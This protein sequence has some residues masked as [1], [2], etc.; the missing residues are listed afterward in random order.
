[1]SPS[2]AGDTEGPLTFREGWPAVLLMA[3][4]V[5]LAAYSR[6]LISPLLVTIAAE[7][8]ISFEAATD[9]FLPISG[10]FVL[11][12][13]LSGHVS[14]RL[15]HRGT[16]IFSGLLTAVALGLCALVASKEAF[17]VCLFLLGLGPGTYAGSGLPATSELIRREEVAT[18]IS[19]HELGPAIGFVAAPITVAVLG[20][21]LGRPGVLGIAAGVCLL[22]TLLYVLFGR[23]GEGRGTPLSFRTVRRYLGS[24]RFVLILVIF[25]LVAACAFGVYSILPGYLIVFHR[26]DPEL[27]NTLVGVSRISGIAVL[28]LSGRLA[29]RIGNRRI[30]AWSLGVTG[31][32]TVGLGAL[33][34]APLLIVVFLQPF[35]VPAFFPAAF[36]QIARLS[37]GASQN[38]ALALVIAGANLMG[39]GAFPRLAGSL[40]AAGVF[41]LAFVML[42]G[43]ALI[44]TIAAWIAFRRW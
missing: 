30:I 3:G 26:F 32:L 18:A 29:D 11:A 21:E 43:A 16:I 8:E 20:P 28:L 12:L 37:D 33:G 40:Q 42:G 4:M 25:V 24:T 36:S 19:V 39:I 27:V 9:F 41:N 14:S 34:G 22:F 35:L 13:L 2:R 31:A 44:A 15:R 1:M 7:L 10:G 23:G 17:M 38:V 5:F 6:L